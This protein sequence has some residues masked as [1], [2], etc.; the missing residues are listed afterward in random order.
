MKIMS[1][2]SAISAVL[3]LAVCFGAE[4]A[5]KNRVDITDCE[6]NETAGGDF[7]CTIDFTGAA[8]AEDED[9]HA[10]VTTEQDGVLD[11]DGI[12]PAT[13]KAQTD[14]QGIAGT[15]PYIATCDGAPLPSALCT[16]DLQAGFFFGI[17]AKV[18]ADADPEAH[19][20]ATRVLKDNY[21]NCTINYYSP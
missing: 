6:C 16:A 19:G 15:G 12:T 7:N 20:K 21:P 11:A 10:H 13:C 8:P 17:V 2:A 9:Y 1:T 14:C 5:N 4:A 18:A 3:L